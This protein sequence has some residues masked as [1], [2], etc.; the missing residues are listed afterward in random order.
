MS[1]EGQ[2]E[3]KPKREFL[4]KDE[5]KACW[6]ARDAYWKCLDKNNPKNDEE[7]NV[8]ACVDLKSQFEKVCPQSWVTYFER[9]YHYERFKKEVYKDG[10][11]R[12]KDD[13]YL[14]K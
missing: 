4:K 3:N 7:M 9:K 8:S 11:F 14:K 6:S 12:S 13:E 5:R 10:G 1:E 2:T